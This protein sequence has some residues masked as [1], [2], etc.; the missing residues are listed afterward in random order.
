MMKTALCGVLVLCVLLVIHENSMKVDGAKLD[1]SKKWFDSIKCCLV[2]CKV[3]ELCLPE[4]GTGKG[5]K[6][7]T[8]DDNHKSGG[9]WTKYKM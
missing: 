7:F 2:N 6:C 1:R 5:C 8:Y 3:G 4:L 9:Y